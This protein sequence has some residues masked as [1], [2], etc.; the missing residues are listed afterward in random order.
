[1]ERAHSFIHVK[2][3]KEDDDYFTFTGMATT[4]APDRMND[5]V[6]PMGAKFAD[7]IPLLW[8]HDSHKPVGQ[9]SFGKPTKKGIPFTAKIPKVKEE[10]AVKDRINEAIHSVKYKLVAAVSIGFRVLNNAVEEIENFGLKFLQTEIMELS[11]VTVPANAEAV[12]DSM[13]SFDHDAL[14]ALSRKAFSSKATP[15]GDAGIKRKSVKILPAEGS[16][17]NF[18]EQ[19]KGFEATRQA[20][21]AEMDDIME[22]AA[23]AG[24]TL[25]EEQS[26]RYDELEA[27]VKSIDKH[28]K[29]LHERMSM[30]E[31]QATP[32][33]DHSGM[34]EKAGKVFQKAKVTE[35]LDK[36]IEFARYAM[37]LGAAK[38]D[39][40]TAAAICE[41]RFPHSERL[42]L[43]LR[44]AVSAGTTTDSTWALPLVEYNQFAGDFVDYL[45]P[46]TIIGKFG[47]GG[48][49][50]LRRIPFNVHIRGQTSGGQGYWVGQ[51]APKPLTSFAFNDTYHGYAKVAN[52]AVLTD[53]LVRFSNP[54]AETLVRDSLA[55]ALIERMDTDFIDPTFAGSANVSPASIT[56]DVTQNASS[57][58]DADAVRADVATAMQVFINANI[59]PSSGVWIMSSSTA[60]QLS[61]MRNALGQKEFP[62]IT[63]MGGTFEG[64]PVITSEYV[65]ADSDGGFIY[66]V[67][68][69][70]IYLSDDG[71]VVID[72][73]REASLQMLDNPT[74]NSATATPTTMVS[75]FQ[76]NSIAIRA[77]RWVNWSKRRD[78]AVAVISGVNYSASA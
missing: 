46:M 13:K 42:N 76:T 74:N 63:M 58:T 49:P 12:I 8:Q 34:Q 45:R 53:E 22:K 9:T 31:T 37:C 5:I 73:S 32:V 21:A 20:K 38:G 19:I 11:L 6:D 69:S 39:L 66:L 1:M 61:L 30:E 50:A 64:L 51:G 57:G 15:P 18:Q 35:K 43:V 54:S 26:G 60:L 3:F 67:N 23:D 55:G 36:G 25:D 41:K 17:M 14:A 65:S 59:T 16:L 52:I 47:Q 72:A 75:M 2:E 44:D 24:E 62:D 29:R 70:D 68:A 48:I 10:G 78:A 56:Y 33:Q 27:E 28:L 7:T 71:N 40:S 77:E 4:P